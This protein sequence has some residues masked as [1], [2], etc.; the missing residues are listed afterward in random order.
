M[1]SVGASKADTLFSQLSPTR[2]QFDPSRIVQ[3]TR[4][5]RVAKASV[6]R[7]GR[8]GF[9][10]GAAKMIDLGPN[11]TVL[12]FEADERNLF[13][14]VVDGRDERGFFLRGIGDYW[15]IAT[16]VY[17]DQAGIDYVAN[18]VDYEITELPDKFEGRPVFFLRYRE[19]ARGTGSDGAGD[20]VV[21]ADSAPEP[22]T[23]N[24]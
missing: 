5:S 9:S 12:I 20:G 22:Q 18:V 10:Q 8:L 23:L 24:P 16:K 13:L 15:Y 11:K 3:A 7:T 6:H 19:H 4:L 21:D 14:V 2:M 17:Y 1:R